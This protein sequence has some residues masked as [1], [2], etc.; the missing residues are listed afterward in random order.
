MTIY[1]ALLYSI[2]LGPGRR[3]VM[4]DLKAMATALGLREPRTVAATGNLV[5]SARRTPPA[6]LEARLEAAFAG[7]FGR[8]VDFVVRSAADWRRLVASNPFP[9]ESET[10]PS[11]VIAQV[12]R[13]PA[14][15][16]QVEALCP[17][18][19]E[20][21]QVVVAAGTLWL[22]FPHGI[23]RSKL[24]AAITP[25]RVGIGTARNWNTVRRLVEKLDG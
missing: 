8:H 19:V 25:R 16:A 2:V 9:R 24:A 6:K 14:T 15:E 21:E 20:G 12:S 1:V 10:D 13:A 17:Y 5:F 7:T 4:A 22:Y 3:V 18:A 23:A 11:H